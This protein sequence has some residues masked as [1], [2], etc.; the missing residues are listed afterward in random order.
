MPPIILENE[1][2]TINMEIEQIMNKLKSKLEHFNILKNRKIFHFTN[3]KKL[4]FEKRFSQ[5]VK[6]RKVEF[7]WI[8]N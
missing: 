7:N 3:N 1:S 6:K 5:I 2:K 4:N 8:K